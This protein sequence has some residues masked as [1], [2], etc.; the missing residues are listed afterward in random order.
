MPVSKSKPQNPANDST[1]S[2]ATAAE[3]KRYPRSQGRGENLKTLHFWK[4]FTNFLLYQ[5]RLKL[6]CNKRLFLMTLVVCLGLLFCFRMHLWA[7]TCNTKGLAWCVII[8]FYETLKTTIQAKLKIAYFCLGISYL[9]IS[10]VDFDLT[11]KY[12]ICYNFI[13]SNIRRC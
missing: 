6:N 3:Q 10:E 13:M 1:T 9:G 8:C 12:R 11:E 5:Q 2:E 4:V 7:T